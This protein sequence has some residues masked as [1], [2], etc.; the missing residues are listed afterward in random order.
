MYTTQRQTSPMVALWLAIQALRLAIMVEQKRTLAYIP[1]LDGLRAISVMAILVYHLMPNWLPGGFVGVD[2]FFII[3]GFL[4]TSLLLDE[5]QNNGRINLPLFYMRRFK[6]L[7]PS[8]ILVILIAVIAAYFLF[9]VN[10]FISLT[11]TALVSVFGVSNFYFYQTASYFDLNSIEKPFLHI[12]SLNV[13]EQFYLIWP[14]LLL[15]TAKLALKHT[16]K[17]FIL[18]VI[19]FLISVYFNLNHPVATFYL[20]FFRFYEFLLGAG[21]ALLTKKLPAYRRHQGATFCASLIGLSLTFFFIDSS[22]LLPGPVSLLFIIPTTYLIA[23][24]NLKSRFNLLEMPPIVKIGKRSYTLYLVHWPII[25]FYLDSNS[26]KELGILEACVLLLITF[27]LAEIIYQFYEV[28]LRNSQNDS[29]V[30]LF[31]VFTLFFLVI[32]LCLSTLS[33]DKKP[34]SNQRPLIFTQADIDS[35]KQSRFITRIKICEIKGWENCDTPES[36]KFNVLI[37]GDSHAV[38]ALNAM[39]EVFPEFDYSMSQLGGCPPTKRMNELVPRTFPDLE[40]CLDLNNQRFNP[41]YIEKFDLIVVN[42][43]FGWYPAS[44]LIGYL[45]FLNSNGVERVVVFG[46]YFEMKEDLPLLINSSGY[47][48][49]RIQKFVLPLK[50]PKASIMEFTKNVDYFYVDKFKNLEGSVESAFW[51]SGFLFTWDTHHLSY[52]FSSE[53]LKRDFDNLNQYIFGR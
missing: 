14:L 6:R 53:L 19:L 21:V 32:S 18:V 5:I 25:V 45:K 51:N 16:G 36:N 7:F 37:L 13:E 15:I 30:F 52:D 1:H 34:L 35:G 24:G 22:S 17:F 28:P 44:E 47:D 42:V 27:L 11:K 33:L 23:N 43:M 46:E 12:W 26:K 49:L 3:S 9:D 4:I 10:K 39:Y 20:P 40:E 29:K 50:D 8:F 48:M 38:D 2:I 31:T 41:K